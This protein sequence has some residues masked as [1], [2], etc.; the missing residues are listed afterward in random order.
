MTG[1][2]HDSPKGPPVLRTATEQIAWMEAVLAIELA[3]YK[4]DPQSF[5][6]KVPK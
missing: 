6:D 2:M 1:P 3:R 4:H 5:R